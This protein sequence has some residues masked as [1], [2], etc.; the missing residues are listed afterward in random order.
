MKPLL[1]FAKDFATCEEVLK[2][3]DGAEELF[4]PLG[5]A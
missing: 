2:T 1:L 3:S 4:A 5:S